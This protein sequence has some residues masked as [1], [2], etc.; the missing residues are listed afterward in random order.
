MED[1]CLVRSDHGSLR[2]LMNFRNFCDG[3]LARFIEIL[4]NYQFTIEYRPSA[5]HNNADR[6]SRRPC[7][8]KNCGHCERFERRCG[9]NLPGLATRKTIMLNEESTKIMK[10]A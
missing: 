1:T 9:E 2:W 5:L 6:L 8:D 4:A 3:Q 10:L 7:I